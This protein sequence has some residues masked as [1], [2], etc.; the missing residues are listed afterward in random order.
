MKWC[1]IVLFRV[2]PYVQSFQMLYLPDSRESDLRFRATTASSES[3]LKEFYSQKIVSSRRRKD[4]QETIGM[5]GE[6][7]SNNP[8]HETLVIKVEDN[9]KRLLI[10]KKMK[11]SKL[12]LDSWP[13]YHRQT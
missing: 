8:E 9:N 7:S 12:I 5:D 6:R 2:L 13:S 1:L 3:W 10:P 4:R 11:A